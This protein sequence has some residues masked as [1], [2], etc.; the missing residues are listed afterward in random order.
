MP[1][2]DNNYGFDGNPDIYGIGIRV[3][4]YTQALTIWVANLWAPQEA[5]FTQSVTIQFLV[6]LL[7]G[8]CVLCRNPTDTYAVEPYMLMQVAYYTMTMS[9]LGRPTPELLI[10]DVHYKSRFI[11]DGIYLGMSSFDLWFWWFGVYQLKPTATPQGTPVFFVYFGQTD[12]FGWVRY[13]AREVNVMSLLLIMLDMLCV[14]IYRRMQK[15]LDHS[16]TPAKLKEQAAAWLEMHQRRPAVKSPSDND[17]PISRDRSQAPSRASGGGKDIRGES[18]KELELGLRETWATAPPPYHPRRTHTG[19]LKRVMFGRSGLNAQLINKPPTVCTTTYTPCLANL[20]AAE[21]LLENINPPP[22]KRSVWMRR[23]RGLSM[24]F[25]AMFLFFRLL[26]SLTTHRVRPGI[27][28]ALLSHQRNLGCSCRTNSSASVRLALTQPA[29]AD[30]SIHAADIMLA[31]RLHLALHPPAAPTRADTLRWAWSQ[32]SA[33]SILVIGTELTIQ[34]NYIKGVQTIAN[35]G[36]MV[37]FAIGVCGLTK[38]VWVALCDAA[39]GR[40]VTEEE[41]AYR[42][43]GFTVTVERKAWVEAAE[44]WDAART[45]YLR[46]VRS[47]QGA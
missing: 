7:V 5:P 40:V 18:T 34:W 41:R 20:F 36:Q 13:V 23:L 12:L 19:L 16:V 30:P 10:W 38:V 29:Y 8:V 11:L 45:E 26:L 25:R 21:E 28:F 46:Q 1:G 14:L 15:R 4:Y 27:I 6:A 47:E 2:D 24:P 3:G 39:K 44:A 33:C 32:F 42:F 31:S 37:P 9:F 17:D 43:G 22:P 35:V